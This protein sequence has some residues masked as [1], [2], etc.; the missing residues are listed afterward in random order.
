M[1]LILK[2]WS[3]TH[4]EDKV[5]VEAAAQVGRGADV[6]KRVHAYHVDDRAYHARRVL[7]GK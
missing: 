7:H 2:Q 5:P 1:F 6:E 3:V 4:L